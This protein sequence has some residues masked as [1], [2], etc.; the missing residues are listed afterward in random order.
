L[1]LILTDGTIWPYKG[2]F[3]FADRQVETQTGTL[4]IAILF[5][6]PEN[7]LRPGQFGKVSA[8][9]NTEKGALWVPQRAVGEFQGI[10]QVAVVD[11]DN[12]VHIR[13]IKVGQ[14]FQDFWIIREGLAPGERGIAEGTQKVGNGVKI[15]SK[16][17]SENE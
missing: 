11:A 13:G 8:L 6:N 10:Y 2:E 12:T 17:I 9:M 1:T 16:P 4:R 7:L 3:S 14:R 15:T 5:A